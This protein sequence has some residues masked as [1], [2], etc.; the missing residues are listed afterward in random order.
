MYNT[1]C[2]NYAN[3]VIKSFL[4]ETQAAKSPPMLLHNLEHSFCS[5]HDSKAILVVT[6]KGF[7]CALFFV[8]DSVMITIGTKGRHHVKS[9]SSLSG[10]KSSRNFWA[11]NGPTIYF[12]IPFPIVHD[13]MWNFWVQLVFFCFYI[14]IYY[15]NFCT[16]SY[17]LQYIYIGHH[18]WHYVASSCNLTFPRH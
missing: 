16:Q 7:V 13:S 6:Y 18:K 10:K 8:L 14:L 11:G 15:E 17:I 1:Q 4:H 2:L 9:G 3:V 12:F 5:H